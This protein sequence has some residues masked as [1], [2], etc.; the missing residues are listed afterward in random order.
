MHNHKSI[1]LIPV[2]FVLMLKTSY[3]FF[4]QLSLETKNLAGEEKSWRKDIKELEQAN[5]KL[6]TLEE[7]IEK[8]IALQ[9]ELINITQKSFQEK[10]SIQ[11]EEDKY[12]LKLVAFQ[13]AD[14]NIVLIIEECFLQK[15]AIEK[16]EF[17]WRIFYEEVLANMHIDIAEKMFSELY[18][19]ETNKF[20]LSEKDKTHT[21][22]IENKKRSYLC[23]FVA[24]EKNNSAQYYHIKRALVFLLIVKKEDLQRDSE[25]SR[26]KNLF[27]TSKIIPIKLDQNC[28]KNFRKI[29]KKQEEAYRSIKKLKDLNYDTTEKIIDP[30]RGL[31]QKEESIE[32]D[33]NTGKFYVKLQ[34]Y[35]ILSK[36]PFLGKVEYY[37][38]YYGYSPEDFFLQIF[39]EKTPEETIENLENHLTW[40]LQIFKNKGFKLGSSYIKDNKYFA[41]IAC[42]FDSYSGELQ[43]NICLDKNAAQKCLEIRNSVESLIKANYR[44]IIRYTAE[45]HICDDY[46]CEGWC[47]DELTDY[48]LNWDKNYETA[49]TVVRSKKS[50]VMFRIPLN[51]HALEECKKQEYIIKTFIDAGY[52]FKEIYS[53]DYFYKPTSTK[54]LISVAHIMSP[55][56][57]FEVELDE[58]SLENIVATQKKFMTEEETKR[59]EALLKKLKDANY[60]PELL[61]DLDHKSNPKEIMVRIPSKYESKRFFEVELNEES[62]EKVQAFEKK[63]M[64]E[65]GYKN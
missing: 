17:D 16:E 47:M 36:K 26:E 2:F 54:T 44:P 52:I 48:V 49:W 18:T 24:V 28:I 7:K 20:G 58:K 53:S 40:L 30:Y 31:K 51:E 56:N 42:L 63:I 37:E 23:Y 15:D 60:K 13:A 11:D 59:V 1:S 65:K 57:F 50:C 64:V 12:W 5:R 39:L 21:I 29:S 34:L 25:C 41:F 45:G 35:P 62:L 9:N 61:K 4:V 33:E 27:K 55:E 3:I 8:P 32:F 43:I 6:L 38:P 46:E 14:K 10:E 22:S 19:E